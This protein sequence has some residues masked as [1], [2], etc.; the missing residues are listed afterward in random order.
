MQQSIP[1]G[2]TATH[3]ISQ[4]KLSVSTQASSH[5]ARL[6][7]CPTPWQLF[8]LMR[9]VLGLAAAI[10]FVI[11]TVE[12]GFYG[13][14]TLFGATEYNDNYGGYQ[15]KFI[16]QYVG[17][18]TIRESPLFT[19]VL[20]GDSMPHSDAAYLHSGD[21]ATNTM[22]EGVSS[23]NAWL[24]SNEYTRSNWNNI[25]T[26]T[27]YNLTFLLD[28]ELIAPV[29]D[30]SFSA[31]TMNDITT[32]RVFYL[33]R[34]KADPNDVFLVVVSL[35]TQDYVAPEQFQ[36]GAAAFICLSIV[37][38]MRQT[39]V[40]R[41]YALSLGYP[42]EGPLYSV[43]TQEGRTKDGFLI[44]DNIPEDPTTTYR[45]RVLTAARSGFYLKSEETQ[46]NVKNMHRNL[47]DDPIRAITTWQ[48]AGCSIIL[49]TWGWVR[50]MHFIFAADTTLNLVV[51]MIVIYRNFQR[52]KIW[53]GDAFVSIS[54]SLQ[55]R[56][57]VVV[58]MWAMENFWQLSSLALKYGTLHGNSVNVFSFSQIMHGDLMVVYVCLTG[59]LGQLL[60]E[61]IDPAMTIILYEVGFRNYTAL[62]DWFP[63]LKDRVVRYADED[64]MRGVADI[65][66]AL[67]GFSPFGFWTKHPLTQDVA[68]TAAAVTPL[69]MTYAIVIIYAVF[70]KTYRRVYPS[71]AI[72]YSSKLTNGSSNMS[73]GRGIKSPFTMF[74]LATGAELQNRVGLVSDYDNCVYIKGM[75]YASAD[76][77]Y[78]NGFVIANGQWLL[79]TADLWSVLLIIITRTRL[80]DV[81]VYE[82][83][84][85]RASQAAVLVYPNTMTLGDLTKLNTTILA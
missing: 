71:L 12:S 25:V 74:E 57:V 39:S 54:N 78:C 16:Q 72:A 27:S 84:D 56:G 37:R 6:G 1:K 60:H 55:F 33:L 34:A 11:S 21:K 35:S 24:Y 43:Y 44:L 63:A 28:S 18:K 4:K 62:I 15:T 52:R 68:A 36:D 41:H 65:P 80:R 8:H 46:A 19:H 7:K 50:C 20:N 17:S 53:V 32:A 64:Y 38:D 73:E 66:E 3:P 30:C 5:S 40:E 67:N 42:Y 77:I 49:N 61:R 85:H 22:C 48:W 69:F 82:V 9:R 31:I 76:G 23:T 59:Y 47:F 45:R 75:R 51:L 81:Y 2:L 29:V 70:R 83:K 14:H 13:M 10:F 58:V 79:R 26:Q